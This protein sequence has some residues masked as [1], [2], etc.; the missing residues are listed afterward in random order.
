VSVLGWGNH[1]GKPWDFA[2]K[3]TDFTTKKRFKQAEKMMKTGDLL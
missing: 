2:W 3:N 1:G